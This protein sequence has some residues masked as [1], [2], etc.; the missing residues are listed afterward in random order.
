MSGG[1]R[2]SEIYRGFTIYYT[3]PPERVW[4]FRPTSDTALESHRSAFQARRAIDI[5]T[6]GFATSTPRRD[7]GVTSKPR[8]SVQE[9]VPE[10]RR[11]ARPTRALPEGTVDDEIG[12]LLGAETIRSVDVVLP[13]SGSHV[14]VRAYQRRERRHVGELP[15]NFRT[16]PNK[17]AVEWEGS[18]LYPEFAI[19]RRLEA[20]G[21]GAAWRK[22]WH[23]AALWQVIEDVADVTPRV[24]GTF[25]EIARD[26]GAGAWDILA[27]NG[28]RVVFIEAKQYGSDKLTPYQLRWLEVALDRGIPLESIAVFEYRAD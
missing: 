19:V 11:A 16:V 12:R 22:N 8:A 26:A 15:A 21:W 17:V 5:L 7:T 13:A 23:G 1:T 9:F 14:T 2:I 3:P 6:D 24:L 18:A 28:D 20:A 4:S 27:W 10:S 25:T